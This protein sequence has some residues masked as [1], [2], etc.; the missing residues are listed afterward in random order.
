MVIL[1]FGALAVVFCFVVWL[2]IK[3]SRWATLIA[4][5]MLS[6]V[7]GAFPWPTVKIPGAATGLLLLVSLVAVA[8][9]LADQLRRSARAL[10]NGYLKWLFGFTMLL[11]A[12]F[13][14]SNNK[15]YGWQKIQYFVLKSVIPLV[16]FTLLA[17]FSKRDVKVIFG[18]VVVGSVLCALNL[19]T[20]GDLSTARAVTAEQ[21]NPIT[22]AREICVGAVVGIIWAIVVF[23]SNRTK[24]SK[25][26]YGVGLTLVSLALF[27]VAAV[28]GSRGPIGVGLFSIVVLIGLTLVGGA[29]KARTV[30]SVC[31]LGLILFAA[32]T[33]VGPGMG[34]TAGMDRILD[35]A[36]AGKIIEN[37]RERLHL[38]QRGLDLA[39]ANPIV[40][41]GVGGFSEKGRI[42][43]HNLF[44]EVVSEMGLLGALFLGFL[45]WMPARVLIRA[46]TLGKIDPEKCGLMSIWLFALGN[47]MVS[48]DLAS[49]Y[50]VWI[51]G[52]FSGILYL[53][54]KGRGLKGGSRPRRSRLRH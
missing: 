23:K 39:I 18:A 49:N 50:M 8:Q 21:R 26:V 36:E 32:I 48:G 27:S 54:T 20:Y 6:L 9:G 2:G 24:R 45:I 31:G 1:Y 25:V 5:T 16:G 40:G 30:F 14:I 15:D 34:T 13:I 37:D 41:V 44:V 47:A 7:L 42:Y 35:Y 53:P 3:D 46:F 52:G 11:L 12:G 38:I 29:Q 22:Y 17:P 43:P 4:L 19:L 28:T 10:Q 33:T 51:A